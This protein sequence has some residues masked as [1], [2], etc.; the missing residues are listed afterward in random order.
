MKKTIIL[1]VITL[2]IGFL[3]AAGNDSRLIGTWKPITYQIHGTDYPMEGLVIF[4]KNHF[5][6]NV[7]FSM[8][9]G[10]GDDANANAGLYKTEGNKIV[11]KQWIQIHIR[12]GDSKEPIQF[13]HQAVEEATYQLERGRLVITFP[14]RNSFIL[15]RIYE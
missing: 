12:P 3:S 5:S 14:S 8:T 15:E 9:G 4:T 10:S 2:S 1:L 7:Q 6:S 13:P 11:F